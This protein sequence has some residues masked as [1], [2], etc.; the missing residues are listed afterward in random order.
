LGII[1]VIST[2]LDIIPHTTI[3]GAFLLTGYLRRGI[4]THL[5]IGAGAFPILFPV[6]LEA[7][8]SA[9]FICAT[10]EKRT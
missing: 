5:R 9:A 8:I 2:I 4:A 10:D 1:I 6:V 3:P 7:F